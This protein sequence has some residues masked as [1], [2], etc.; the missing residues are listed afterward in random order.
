MNKKL[1]LLW[2]VVILNSGCSGLLSN[3]FEGNGKTVSVEYLSQYEGRGSVSTLWY[4]GSDAKYHYF[5][6]YVKASTRYRIPRAEL[7][8]QNE[9]K[10]NTGKKFVL[11][12]GELSTYVKNNP[13]QKDQ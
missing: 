1:Y 3:P 5:V 11:V 7:D 2:I 4:R 13:Q 10:L 8:W 12:A 6:H 9:F